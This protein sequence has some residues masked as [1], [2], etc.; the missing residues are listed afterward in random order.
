MRLALALTLVLTVPVLDLA[1]M[2]LAVSRF[3]LVLDLAEL[4]LCFPALLHELAALEGR[5]TALL[6][7]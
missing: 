7:F 2:P 1:A 4:W 3:A 5:A 6:V